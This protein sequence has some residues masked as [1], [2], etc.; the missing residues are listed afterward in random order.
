MNK[1][2]TYV[3]ILIFFSATIHAMD[4]AS[5]GH[6]LIHAAKTGN[7]EEVKRLL[8]ANAPVNYIDHGL[9]S[10][11]LIEATCKGHSDSLRLLID[12]KASLD[13]KEA[14]GYTALMNA[15][16]GGGSE[17]LQMLIEAKASL[18]LENIKG[19]TALMEAIR[20][21]KFYCAYLLIE[22]KA[23]ISHENK[24][25]VTALYLATYEKHPACIY[26]LIHAQLSPDCM[27]INRREFTEYALKKCGN[28]YKKKLICMFLGCLKK[29]DRFREIYRLREWMFKDFF[30]REHLAASIV[31]RE[32]ARLAENLERQAFLEIAN[33]IENADS[34]DRDVSNRQSC[35]DLQ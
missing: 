30:L 25:G 1:L 22:A 27:L 33:D 9:D 32:N 34:Q 3:C 19:N 28:R 29:Q 16:S 11:A 17:C 5:L 13:Y 4:N 2:I 24:N 31:N 15:A 10:T 20:N 18:D 7:Q 23:S 21:D 6:Q 8:D 12:A 35:C 14:L 26:M